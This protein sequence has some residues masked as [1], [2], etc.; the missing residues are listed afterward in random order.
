MNTSPLDKKALVLML[1]YDSEKFNDKIYDS[2]DSLG[3]FDFED[4]R[5]IE[6]LNSIGK[7]FGI[8]FTDTDN[9]DYLN[10]FLHQNMWK[11]AKDNYNYQEYVEPKL[12][13][14]IVNASEDYIASISDNYKLNFEGYTENYARFLITNGEITIADGKFTHQYI[15][16]T[17]DGD[18]VV[19]DIEEIKSDITENTKKSNKLHKKDFL[20]H[21]EDE[22]DVEMLDL[23]I[24]VI[25][26]R[27]KLLNQ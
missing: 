27:K 19:H 22:N 21:I 6:H 23:M 7:Y 4:N 1:K 9:L 5:L 12:K 3:Y 16:D 14:F 17:W 20:S 10:E 2:I 8:D 15:H 18:Y 13:K 25:E 26:K 24:Q 11:L